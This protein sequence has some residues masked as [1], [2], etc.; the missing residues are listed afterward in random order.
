MKKILI[1]H[2]GGTFGMVSTEPDQVLTPG[3][4]QNELQKHVPE[5]NQIAD[6]EINILFNEDSSNLGIYHW[7]TLAG[8][9]DGN[10]HKYDGFVIIHG[11]DT[12]VYSAAALSFSLLNLSKPVILTGAQIPLAK[13]RSDARQNLIDAIEVSTQQLAEVLIVF[14]QKIL[15]GNRARKTSITNYGAFYSPNY[16]EIGNIGINLEIDEKECLKSNEKYKFLAGFESSVL[17]IHVFPG[18]NPDFYY[19]AL[20]KVEIRAFILIGFGSGNI[21]VKEAGWLDFIRRSIELGKP[22][23]VNSSSAHGKINLNY[24]ENGEKMLAAGAIGCEDMTVE[25][26][27]VKIMKGLAHKSNPRSL[28]EFF[29]TNLA[30]EISVKNIIK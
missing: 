1:V 28:K 18:C 7:S 22:V 29:L 21:P 16:P 27:I 6:I 11:T 8:I 24:Y 14:G 15:R 30:G 5:I 17:S 25:A 4:L 3:N 13:L 12:M 19:D 2:T 10:M 9:I 23:F 20:N 26:S